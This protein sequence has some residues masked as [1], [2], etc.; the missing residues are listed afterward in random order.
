MANK[1]IDVREIKLHPLCQKCL[2]IFAFL[3]TLKFLLGIFLGCRSCSSNFRISLSQRK[4]RR[5]Q[6]RKFLMT[7][8]VQ[9][10]FEVFWT[11]KFTFLRHHQHK[12]LCK[13]HPLG[14]GAICVFDLT[15]IFN[16]HTCISQFLLIICLYLNITWMAISIII[17]GMKLSVYLEIAIP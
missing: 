14:R 13:P 2:L 15:N 1:F 9:V 5:S 4:P 8:K 6:K 10:N 17:T 11:P 7:I 12:G 3:N 16:I